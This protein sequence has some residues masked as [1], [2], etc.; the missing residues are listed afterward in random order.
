[1]AAYNAL[2]VFDGWDHFR[3]DAEAAAPALVG[4]LDGFLKPVWGRRLEPRDFAHGDLN[5]TNILTHGHT[6]TG[7]VD[8]DEIG[9]NSRT[10]HLTSILFDWHALSLRGA[11]GLAPRGGAITARPDRLDRRRGRPAVHDR[12]RGTRPARDDLSP[13]SA[14][15]AHRM[16][17]GD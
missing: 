14:R 2:V 9:L 10:A 8:W 3:H 7:I 4:R 1:M 16:D 6:I 5:L 17:A 15:G 13:P 12:V 11:P